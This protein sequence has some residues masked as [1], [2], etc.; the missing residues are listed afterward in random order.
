MFTVIKHFRVLWWCIC[1]SLSKSV[2]GEVDRASWSFYILFHFVFSCLFSASWNRYKPIKELI[3]FLKKGKMAAVYLKMKIWWLEASQTCLAASKINGKTHLG[4]NYFPLN[5]F[6]PME[7]FK[8]YGIFNE[9]LFNS[10]YI[11]RV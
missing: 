4:W 7:F 8:I 2:W 6:Y 10:L 5:F 1:L 11:C 3:M 9:I